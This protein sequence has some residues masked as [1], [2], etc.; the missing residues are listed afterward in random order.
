MPTSPST[1]GPE[2]AARCREL[3]A[4]VAVD[5]R[6]I[7]GT[8]VADVVLEATDGRGVD[9]VLD[10]LGAGG[11]EE[12]T[13]CLATGG[14]L[15]VI[16]LLRGRRGELDLGRL[17]AKRASLHATTLRSRPAAEKAEIVSDVRARVWP[18][19][20][21]G[22]LRPVVDQRVPLAEAGR[23][24]DLLESGSVFGKVL[25]LPRQAGVSP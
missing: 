25:L 20:D 7:E 21:D 23:A 8:G 15:V 2:R 9:V 16:G 12:N 3:G 6:A 13:R 24:H 14:R 1:T 18:M 4:D 19:L 22:R 11:L 5:H 10:I 17:L